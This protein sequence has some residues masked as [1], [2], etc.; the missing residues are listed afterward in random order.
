MPS[1]P[2]QDNSKDKSDGLQDDKL[3]HPLVLFVEE[4]LF[5]HGGV[6]SSIAK[7]N[8]SLTNQVC[9]LGAITNLGGTKV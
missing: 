4:T 3:W 2:L 5:I 6:I 9:I 7:E 8:A 1:F